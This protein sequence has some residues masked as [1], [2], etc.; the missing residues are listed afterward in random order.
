MR[1]GLV[2]ALVFCFYP[3]FVRGE[4]VESVFVGTP[5]KF[6]AN[7]ES[8]PV[9]DIS[10]WEVTRQSRIEFRISDMATAYLGLDVERKIYHDTDSGEFMEVFSRHIPL[11]PSRQKIPDNRLVREVVALERVRQEEENRL[12]ELEKETD[13]FLYIY[14]RVRTNPNN[15]NDALDGDVNIWF[16]PSDGSC[17]FFQ[18]E[19]VDIQFMTENMGDPEKLRNGAG[20]KPRNVFVGVKYQISGVY[21]ILKVDRRDVANLMEREK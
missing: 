17:R 11:I 14:W 16:M 2:L 8:P 10:G 21:H 1:K 12:A 3:Y 9:P 13:V 15:G 6:P 7:C 5:K 4:P 19:L 20:G 18:N